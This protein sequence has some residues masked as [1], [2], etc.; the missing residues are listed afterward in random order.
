[1]RG[2]VRAQAV[3]SEENP[4]IYENADRS[5][6][7]TDADVACPGHPVALVRG[8]EVADVEPVREALDDFPGVV[9]GAIV[10]DENLELRHRQILSNQGK[11]CEGEK[12]RTVIRGHND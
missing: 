9:G 3:R 8:M 4:R 7:R 11:Q 6:R 5:K 2:A 12:A 1:M 10:D